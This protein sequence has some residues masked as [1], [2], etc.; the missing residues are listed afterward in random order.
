MRITFFKSLFIILNLLFY[1]PAFGNA[2]GCGSNTG[3]NLGNSGYVDQCRNQLG[4]CLSQTCQTVQ[5]CN[6]T[7]DDLLSCLNNS[8]A[9]ID[10]CSLKFQACQKGN[11]NTKCLPGGVK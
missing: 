1:I 5:K 2:V 6:G 7:N 3:A 10:N 11:T 8:K 4:E 9:A